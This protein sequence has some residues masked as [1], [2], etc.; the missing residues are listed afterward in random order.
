M[1]LSM[2]QI[3]FDVFGGENY[4]DQSQL[5]VRRS[6][7]Q[8]QGGWAQRFP[9]ESPKARN[10]DFSPDGMPKRLGSAAYNAAADISDVLIS[11]DTVIGKGIEF[12]SP[13]TG[14]TR[15]QIQGSVKG[16]YIDP[17]TGTWAVMKTNADV[18]FA[19]PSDASKINLTVVDNHLIITADV[20]IIQIFRTAKLDDPLHNSTTGTTCN[21][22]SASGQKTLLVN[23]DTSGFRVGDRIVIDEAA[24]NNGPIYGYI[25]SIVADTSFEMEANLSAATVDTNTV[26]ILNIYNDSF[27]GGTNEV[28]GN[29][30]DGYYITFGMHER[31]CMST[32]NSVIEYTPA[33]TIYDRAGSDAGFR[34]AQGNVEAA[35]VF[36]PQG[37][38]ENTAIG[39]I[40][41][42][43]GGEYI[44]GFDATDTQQPPRGQ[45]TAMNHQCMIATNNWIMYLTKD[46]GIE[47]TNTIDTIDVGRRFK[48]NDGVTGPLDTINNSQAESLAFGFWD[49]DKKQGGWYIPNGTDTVIS[50]A[51]VLD[52]KLGEPMPGEPIESFERRVRPLTWTINTPATNPWFRGV[53][54]RF[55]GVV[56]VLATGTLW[57][58]NSGL[59]DLGSLA[60]LDEWS[61]P[62]F[63]GGNSGRQ[64][65]IRVVR[66]QTAEKGKWNV[67][68]ESFLNRSGVARN[69]W[70]FPQLGQG[71]SVYDTAVYGDSYATG[72]SANHAEHVELLCKIF[73][74]RLYN[75]TASQDWALQHLQIQYQMMKEE[76]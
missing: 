25:D 69:S 9:V 62:E 44:S 57:T 31:L 61:I 16:I 70:T 19:W 27:G 14:G 8:V 21:G 53:Y 66:V 33:Q 67:T 30:E 2:Q 40:S 24:A 71:T 74:G 39:Y 12:Q 68:W 22:V 65:K 37:R 11:G 32:G 52:F 35:M 47:A 28:T 23:A 54:K 75:Q 51:V 59:D 4:A 1:A 60:V 63:D 73:R 17:G 3:E 20:G 46:G 48:A 7:Q 34:Q 76:D 42:S 43:V 13:G 18:N 15:N 45:R 10:M 6:H 64:K 58:L 55:G 41:T 29:W 36:V 72:A 26:T 5:L 56:G 38:S 50:V 49:D